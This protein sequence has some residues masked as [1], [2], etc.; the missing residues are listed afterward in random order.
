[1][2]N[3]T[4][5]HLEQLDQEDPLAPFR[6]EFLLPEGKIYLNGNSLVALLAGLAIFPLI[7]SFGLEPR[8]GPG[9]VFMTLP[10]AFGQMTGGLVFGALFFVLL[11]FAALTSSIAMLEAPVSWLVDSTKLSRRSAALLA[12]GIAYVL[13]VLAALSFNTLSGVHPLGAISIFS[14]KTFFDLFDYFVTNILMPL[15]GLLIAVFAGWFMK[16]QFSADELFGGET[17]FAYRSWL[18]LVRFLA[19]LILAYVF[20]DMATS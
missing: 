19:P 20:F 11:S 3:L 2:A 15:G 17:T 7:V 18:F 12:G 4:R 6:H 9:L 13:G 1:M 10:L 14:D 5:Q 16:E 8:A